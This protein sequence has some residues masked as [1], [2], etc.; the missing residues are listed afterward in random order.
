[1]FFEPSPIN[2]TVFNTTDNCRIAGTSLNDIVYN[3]NKQV[4]N[5]NLEIATTHGRFQDLFVPTGLIMENCGLE[6]EQSGGC[7]SRFIKSTDVNSINS[8]IFDKL[9]SKVIIKKESHNNTKRNT[10]TS[11]NKTKTRKSWFV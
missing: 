7:S 5:D 1:M 3:Q 9:L 4:S 10:H 2:Q 8:D 6:Q 11:K